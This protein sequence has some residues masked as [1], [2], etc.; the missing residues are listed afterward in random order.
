[1]QK[2]KK[3]SETLPTMGD[4]KICKQGPVVANS[5]SWENEKNPEPEQARWNQLL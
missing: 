4:R 2:K 1:M 3:K 5:L